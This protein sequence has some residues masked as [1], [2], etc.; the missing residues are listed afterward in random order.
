ME[1]ILPS[2]PCC[3]FQR[4]GR[5]HLWTHGDE[6]IFQARMNRPYRLTPIS[7]GSYAP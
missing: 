2:R 1:P 6:C 3:C 5:G 7:E 4:C